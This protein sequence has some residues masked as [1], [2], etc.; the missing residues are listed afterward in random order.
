MSVG[1]IKKKKLPVILTKDYMNKD[2]GW[3]GLNTDIERFGRSRMRGGGGTGKWTLCIVCWKET[4]AINQIFAH[5]DLS[6]PASL[7]FNTNDSSFLPPLKR[8]A[9][10]WSLSERRN[11][12]NTDIFILQHLTSRSNSVNKQRLIQNNCETFIFKPYT[13]L[14]LNATRVGGLIR[15]RGETQNLQ[16]NGSDYWGMCPVFLPVAAEP[17]TFASDRFP[18]TPCCSAAVRPTQTRLPLAAAPVAEYQRLM[19]SLLPSGENLFL[20]SGF[21]GTNRKPASFLCH[22]PH[23]ACICKSSSSLKCL[24]Q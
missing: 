20:L 11:T 14:H 19:L 1:K 18:P 17:Q 5:R 3:V 10:V 22:P 6:P 15:S 12:L 21:A 16:D 13:D 2:R 9:L 23:P 4:D 24:K 7:P 8:A